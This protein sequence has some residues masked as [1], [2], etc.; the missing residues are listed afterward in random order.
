M[1]ELNNPRFFTRP[2]AS[3]SGLVLTP[4]SLG[5]CSFPLRSV[6]ACPGVWP[7][8]PF[9]A[10]FFV[11]SFVHGEKKYVFLYHISYL[12]EKPFFTGFRAFLDQHPIRC[13]IKI[14]TKTTVDGF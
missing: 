3:L 8:P 12:E 13:D 11:L 5:F 9:P 6:E 10:S 7:C 2:L 1:S 14:R 4:N